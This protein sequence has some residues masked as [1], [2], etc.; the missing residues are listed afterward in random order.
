MGKKIFIS[1]VYVL[2][3]GFCIAGLLS[4]VTIKSTYYK[5]VEDKLISNAYLV[6]ELVSKRIEAH[7]FDGLNDY[8]NSIKTYDEV[9]ITVINSQGEVV[10]DTEEDIS[11]M[12]NHK[13]RP[14]VKKALQGL[15]SLESR[16][17]NT[18]NAD[19]LYF[20]LPIK[21]NEDGSI[22]AVRL[23]MALREINLIIK[24]YLFDLFIAFVMGLN[25]A[26]IIGFI[27]SKKIAT[28]LT[29]ITQMSGEIAKGNFDI[30]LNIK[31]DDEIG[32][33]AY[34]INHMSQQIQ[35][36]ISGLNTKNKEM[37]AILSSVASGIIAINKEQKILFINENAKKLLH[38][39]DEELAGKDLIYVLRSHRI[40]EYLN[41]EVMNGEYREI[42]FTLNY[43]EEKIIR[44]YKNP[45]KERDG[46]NT[47]GT[48]IV[49]QDVTHV[50]KLER[51]RSEFVANVSHELKTPLTSIK[52]FIETL[53]EGAI[54][55]EE[56]A[57][58]FLDIVY[59]EAERLVELIDGILTLSEL[60]GKKGK[61]TKERIEL[62]TAIDE[63]IPLFKSKAE[64]KGVTI[65]KDVSD[66]IGYIN[67]SKDRF[68]Q[69]II[70]LIDNA[71]KYS[72]EGGKVTIRGY[73]ENNTKVI[74]VEDNGIG[75][76]EED[77][78][79]IFERFYRVDK[80]RSRNER[81]GSGLG[82][83]IVKHIAQNMGAEI[84]VESKIGKGT[85][86]IIRFPH[87]KGE[88]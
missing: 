44:L 70:N 23:S 33:L 50:R 53:K 24:N 42:E 39:D 48:I 67:G 51:I 66:K 6:G 47:I 4:Y 63:V 25:V 74:S 75:I 3:I 7:G 86:F 22:I 81:S 17:S 64:N 56:T 26:L 79:R 78:P 71:V 54:K 18:I 80:S 1:L 40:H 85:K 84:T 32:K 69:M 46:S 61:E 88:P 87:E 8:V 82:L 10:A 35:Y 9:R 36:Y 21:S 49:L 13:D 76:P 68:K 43:P 38:I 83:S 27:L 73:L 58:R 11:V 28:P 59:N 31:D 34:T 57:L 60:E 14:E 62:S 52:G 19:Y 16:Y 72:K 45:I 5:V 30:K 12:D 65:M 2:L 15:E 55:D 29:K 41:N 20:A 77:L 37:E